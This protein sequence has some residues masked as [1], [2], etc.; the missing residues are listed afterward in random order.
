MTSCG[1]NQNQIK[2][3]KKPASV[4]YKDSHT[5]DEKA[6]D[7]QYGIPGI[8]A[9]KGAVLTTGNSISSNEMLVNNGNKL[10]ALMQSDGN[11]VIYKGY[12]G[13]IWASNTDGKGSGPFKLTMQDDGNLVIYEANGQ[14]T[15][16]SNT[17][18]KG[19]SPF[20]LIMQDDGNLVIYDVNG[21]ATWA[22]NTD[23]T[24]TDNL[25]QNES[26]GDNQFLESVSGQFRLVMQ[27]DGNLV[28]YEQQFGGVQ[29]PIWASGTHF[30]GVPP[31]KLVMQEDGN[32]VVYDVN[33]KATWAS[34]TCGKGSAPFKLVMQDDGN[35]VIYDSNQ[36]ATW[37]TN[38]NRTWPSVLEQG[39]SILT[40]QYLKSKSNICIA[41]MQSDGNFCVYF[42]GLYC[43][44]ATGTNGKGSAPFKVV[45]Q[46]DG[47]LV[48]YDG[49]GSP[50]WAS[51]T[52]KEGTF[53]LSM[54]DD[55]N[56]VIYCDVDLAIW[57]SNTNYLK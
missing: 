15:W 22:S 4:E 23:E 7:I 30:I 56:L 35:L 39:E 43:V 12:K 41:V 3:T 50:T 42:G 45:M 25:V 8:F 11:F 18:G 5:E 17:W 37:A 31:F 54:Q 2:S 16:A 24:W 28:L 38:T 48:V 53:K 6:V 40:N 1:C 9:N 57:A 52:L 36:S 27:H 46:D 32:L 13:S 19:T 34:G 49:Q 55:G 44:W 14:P 26:I 29:T 10:C 47:N 20:K 51:N 33:G 21:V